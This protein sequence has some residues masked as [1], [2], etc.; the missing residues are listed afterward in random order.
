MPRYD[1]VLAVEW[2]RLPD[3]LRLPENRHILKSLTRAANVKNSDRRLDAQLAARIGRD[4]SD[5]KLGW[6]RAVERVTVR[7]DGVIALRC[8]FRR[9]AAWVQAGGF[10][11]LVDQDAVRL[12]GRYEPADC[13]GHLLPVITG[14]ES[15]PAVV[16]KPWPGA[17]LVAGLRITA[18]VAARSFRSEIRHIVVSNHGGRKAR[19]RP[20]IELK[21]THGGSRILWGRAPGEEHG[22]EI[23]AEQKVTLLETLKSRWGR[24]D[25]GRSYVDIRTYHDS[26]ILPAA[27]TATA[28]R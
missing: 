19:N 6:I 16:G 22:T 26:V 5:P 14:V 1:G 10:V 13:E 2:D 17:D 25:L 9:P 28:R 21:T 15:P 7:P 8:D 12:P 4:L 11:Y 24:I 20:H 18:L 23:S 3:W 27:D